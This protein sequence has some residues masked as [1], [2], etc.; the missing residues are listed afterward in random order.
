MFTVSMGASNSTDLC[1]II[2]TDNRKHSFQSQPLLVEEH[3]DNICKTV[4]L[5][6]NLNRRECLPTQKCVFY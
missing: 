6:S 4:S 1:N 3:E 5:E 2:N